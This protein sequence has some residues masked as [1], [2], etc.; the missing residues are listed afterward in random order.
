MDSGF[1]G[2]SLPNNIINF[3]TTLPHML[4]VQRVLAGCHSLVYVDGELVGD[5]LE[6]AA[7]TATGGMSHRFMG[8]SE[9]SQQL[10]C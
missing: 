3:V 10:F 4:Q 2:D 6:L 5:P 9:A 1:V 8:M 7:F